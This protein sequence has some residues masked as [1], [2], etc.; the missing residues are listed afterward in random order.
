[1]KQRGVFNYLLLPLSGIYSLVCYI[2]YFLSSPQKVNAKVICVGNVVIGGSGKTPLCIALAKEHKKVAFISRG[3]KGALSNPVKPLKV[4]QTKHSYLEVGDEPLLLAEV[5]PTYICPNR[6]LAAQLAIKD[7]AKVIIMD[8]GLQNYSLYKD[9]VYIIDNQNTNG[10][11]LPAGNLREPMNLALRKGKLITA[12]TKVQQPSKFKGKSCIAVCSIAH[13]ERFFTALKSTGAKLVGQHAFP[14]HHRYM[15]DEL[16]SLIAKAK[17]QH[18]QLVTT[19]KDYVK[20][21]KFKKEF[22]VLEIVV[23]FKS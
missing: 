14:D 12:R 6:Y 21:G 22:L 11:V 20:L 23:E 17:G 10:M 3:Y 7:G 18:C 2:R 8:D 16:K 15:G 9:E 13:P 4:D 19:S 1:M 5:A